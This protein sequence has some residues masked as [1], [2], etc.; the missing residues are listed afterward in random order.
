MASPWPLFDLRVRTPRLVLRSPTDADVFALLDVARA[1]VHDPAEMPFAVPW[2]DLAHPEFERSFLQFYWGCRSGWSPEAWQLPLAVVLDDRPIGIQDVAAKN[3][4]TLRT[5]ETGSWLG[6]AFQRQGIGTEM[7]AAVLALAFDG[8][9]A[10]VA[11]SGVI[12]GNVASRRVSETLGYE[13]NGEAFVAPRGTPVVEHRYRLLRE[14]WDRDRYPVL[15]EGLD[16]CRPMFG[17]DARA[18]AADPR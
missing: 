15:I 9:G 16:E 6:R 18:D 4:P 13:P 17:L 8:L 12:E 3:F 14:R 1:G 7:R 2:T 11:T 10:E 5:V